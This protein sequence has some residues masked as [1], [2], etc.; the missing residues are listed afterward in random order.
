MIARMLKLFTI[1]A[2]HAFVIILLDPTN[3]FQKCIY[4][5]LDL[6]TSIKS[7]FS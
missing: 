4:L 2:H 5:N 1:I 7:F 3:Y 6:D